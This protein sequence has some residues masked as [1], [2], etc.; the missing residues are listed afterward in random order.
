MSMIRARLIIPLPWIAVEL[1]WIVA[2]YGRQP[3]VVDSILPTA[4]G[5]SSLSVGQVAF[6]LAGFVLLYTVLL[7]GPDGGRG[8]NRGL[9]GAT[10]QAPARLRR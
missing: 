8:G 6:T 4:L 10:P 9:D 7:Q 5:V 3:W 2:E 1:G